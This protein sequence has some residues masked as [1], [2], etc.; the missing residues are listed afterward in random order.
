MF[1]VANMDPE[2]EDASSKCIPYLESQQL[3]TR[4]QS[5][6]IHKAAKV[7]SEMKKQPVN[8]HLAGAQPVVK[9]EGGRDCCEWQRDF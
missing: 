7:T 1:S 3:K 6:S 5:F 4:K 2:R 9:W 8:F